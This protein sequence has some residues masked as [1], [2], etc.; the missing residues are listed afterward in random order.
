MA[1]T[2]EA[3][4]VELDTQKTFADMRLMVTDRWVGLAQSE[5]NH[6]LTKFHFIALEYGLPAP[7]PVKL[8]G[9]QAL[10]HFLERLALAQSAPLNLS[11]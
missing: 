9:E 3:R 6:A 11:Q 2:P 5:Q 4:A 8:N 7:R 10:A 1:I